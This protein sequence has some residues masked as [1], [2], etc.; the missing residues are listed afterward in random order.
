VSSHLRPSIV[1]VYNEHPEPRMTPTRLKGHQ[2]FILM[3]LK[4]GA[5]TRHGL[6]KRYERLLHY[7]GLPVSFA[8]EDRGWR[9]HRELDENLEALVRKGF[10]S[11]DGDSFSLT[12]EGVEVAESAYR[13]A[14]ETEDRFF[15][16]AHSPAIASR[17]SVASYAV[18]TLLKLS[19]GVTF[20]SAALMADGLDSLT[21]VLLATIVLLGVRFGREVVSAAFVVAAMG[22]IGCGVVYEA[23]A[24]IARPVVVHAPLEAFLVVAVAG[25]VSHVLSVYQRRVGKRGGS[26]A[27]IAQAADGRGHVLQAGGVALGLVAARFGFFGVDAVVAIIIGALILRSAVELALEVMHVVRAEQAVGDSR[28]GEFARGFER[29]RW[30]FFKTWTLLTIK[31][32]TSRRDVVLRYDQTFTPDDLPFLSYRSPAAGFDF[33]KNIDGILEE[34]FEEGLISSVGGAL[35]LTD[36]GRSRLNA[37]LRRRRLGFF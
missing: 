29:H 19:A 24:R 12:P 6:R 14:R 16:A 3:A 9:F 8:R 30:N 36:D 21:D 22:L 15:L 10:V 33:R 31:E 27:L 37:S 1:S 7:M 18:L 20:H 28:T 23:M 2:P 17:L 5:K 35:S 11:A 4:S 13:R 25:V 34:L 32:A 26:L